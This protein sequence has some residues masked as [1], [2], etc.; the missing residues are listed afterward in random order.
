MFKLTKLDKRGYKILAYII[1]FFALILALS[2]ISPDSFFVVINILWFLLLA[3]VVAFLG[4]GI[5]VALGLKSE[6]NKLLDLYVDGSLSVIDF[7]GFIKD[8][9]DY[10]IYQLKELLLV[11]SPIFAYALNFFIYY[12]LLMFYKWYG[13]TNDVTFMTVFLTA[14]LV[15]TVSVLNIM[16]AK[17]PKD[18]NKWSTRFFAKLKRD[19]VDA[20]E[21]LIFVFFLTMDSTTLWFLPENLRV[22]L[23]SQF[24]GYDLMTRGYSLDS[25]RITLTL[26]MVGVVSEIVR[27]VLA[28]SVAGKHYFDN[29]MS[30]GRFRTIDALREALRES[31]NQSRDEIVSFITFTTVLLFVF[32]M[33]PRL[34]LLT[35][36]VASVTAL[37]ID[38][39]YP[40]RLAITKKEDLV[41]RLLAKAFK[42]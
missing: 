7:V 24:G 26:V 4:I 12:F 27:N 21:V 33:F 36:A 22:P 18:P 29:L 11:L 31:F 35:L 3:I 28:I 19:F 14:G 15:I 42:L 5:L 16:G 23:H 9:I 37:A 13:T 38:I 10:F 30:T 1:G 6:A 25:T 40:K 32:L 20:L 2:V 8:F 39:I 41:S 17:K 34:K